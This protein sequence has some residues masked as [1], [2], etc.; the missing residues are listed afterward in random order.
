MITYSILNFPTPD[1]PKGE[2]AEAGLAILIN[3]S[4]I[5]LSQIFQAD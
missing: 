5:F 2:G 4:L 1:L 3:S